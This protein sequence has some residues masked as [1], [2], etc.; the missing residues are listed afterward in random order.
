MPPDV[1]SGRTHRQRSAGVRPYWRARSSAGPTS[2]RCESGTAFGRSVVPDVCNTS[3]T[4]SLA[5]RSSALAGRDVPASSVNTPAGSAGENTR[6]I[7]GTD[8]AAAARAAGEPSP[9]TITAS[10]RSVAS[11]TRYDA[12]SNAGLSGMQ[13][14]HPLTEST[15]TAI[16]GP[17]GNANAMRS[18]R[19]KPARARPCIVASMA[20]ASAPNAS[21]DLPGARIARASGATSALTLTMSAMVVGRLFNS[22]PRRERRGDESLLD[23]SD[24]DNAKRTGSCARQAFRARQTVT[25]RRS[26][27]HALH[28]AGLLRREPA[29]A[30]LG[31]ALHIRAAPSRTLG[32]AMNEEIERAPTN[33]HAAPLSFAQQR[34]WLLD[35]L[36]P[37]GSVYNI[38]HA[39]RLS[40]ELD[41]TRSAERA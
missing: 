24:R 23:G 40:G 21:G 6:R 9:A 34:L 2:R 37:L 29:P 5:G 33:E 25:Y 36:I 18:P 13:V 1:K 26:P 19:P 20:R 4:S 12:S 39:L 27:Q 17:S 7:A 22:C 32:Q 14:A 10:A 38:Q 16:S 35:R 41:R 15:A 30:I 28:R 31:N 3:A 11:A 8:N